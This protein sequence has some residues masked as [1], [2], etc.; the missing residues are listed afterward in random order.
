M[1]EQLEKMAIVQA[2]GSSKG[3]SLGTKFSNEWLQ[4]IL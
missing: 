3:A 4:K 2:S 1:L